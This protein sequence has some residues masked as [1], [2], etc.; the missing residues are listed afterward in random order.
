MPKPMPTH[1]ILDARDQVVDWAESP[2]AARR[3]LDAIMAKTREPHTIV[4]RNRLAIDL[5]EAIARA[6]A[7][8]GP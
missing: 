8:K 3:L 6:N 2:I 4:H 5:R 7:I 1:F